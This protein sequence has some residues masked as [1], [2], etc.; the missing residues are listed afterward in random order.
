MRFISARIERAA[1][2]RY[3]Q[4]LYGTNSWIHIRS[5]VSKTASTFDDRLRLLPALPFVL[6]PEEDSLATNGIGCGV[7]G[8][9]YDP[10]IWIRSRLAWAKLISDRTLSPWRDCPEAST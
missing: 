7:A 2:T 5:D 6:N 1:E 3:W 9:M 8:L 10:A 4:R